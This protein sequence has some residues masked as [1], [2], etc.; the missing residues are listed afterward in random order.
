MVSDQELAGCVES[1]L[2]QGGPDAVVS[3]NGVVRQ[4]E[5]KLGLDL[6]HKASFINE[7]IDILLGPQFSKFP[8]ATAAAAAAAA[9]GHHFSQ[10]QMPPA[11]SP[12][13]TIPRRPNDSAFGY[14]SPMTSAT[15]AATAAVNQQHLNRQYY[16]SQ[17]TASPAPAPPRN[18]HLLDVGSRSMVSDVANRNALALIIYSLVVLKAE[19]FR[20]RKRSLCV[21][22]SAPVAPKRRGGPGGLSKVCGVSPELQAIVGE[23]TMARTQIV[24][25]LW[26]YIRKN[27][28]QDPNNKRKIICNDEL[29]LVFETDCT[30]MFK[31][32]KLLAKHIIPLE[33]TKEPVQETKR[34]KRGGTDVAVASEIETSQ[35]PVVISDELAGFFGT[36]EREIIQSDALMRVYDYIKANHLE[37]PMNNM[38]IRCDTKLRQL[39]GC[40]TLSAMEVSEKLSHHLFKQS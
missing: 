8:A 39:F 5:A 12:Y 23:P 29:R 2:R 18:S 20:G 4:L 1:L 26:A 33:P 36:G 35:Y 37:D 22:Q 6:S 11:S 28:L 14:G 19:G 13:A 25:Q 15:S 16:Q 38:V 27:N 34:I 9:G 32:N 40:E 3:V 10:S 31:M 24:K 17:P 7:Q 21:L 30:D